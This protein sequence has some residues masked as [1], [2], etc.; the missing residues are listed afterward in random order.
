MRIAGRYPKGV[1][2][3]PAQVLGVLAVLEQAVLLGVS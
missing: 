3:D 2:C 1:V